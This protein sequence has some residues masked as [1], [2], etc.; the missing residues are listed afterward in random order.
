M[1]ALDVQISGDAQVLAD[2]SKIRQVLTNLIANAI[3]ACGTEGRSRIDIREVPGRLV[4]VA[5]TDSGPGVPADARER[6]FEPFF[7]TKPSGTGL[8]LA[9]SRA[10]AKA[11]GGD[12]ALAE[13]GSAGATFTL[14]LPVGANGEP[15]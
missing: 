7:T 1:T 8:G 2:E 15:A 11:H 13:D 12:V 9:I 5:V 14:S 6:I 3:E 10:I 4:E